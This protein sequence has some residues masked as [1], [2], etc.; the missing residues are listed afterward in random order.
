MIFSDIK[1]GK[2]LRSLRPIL[3]KWIRLNGHYGKMM[4]WSDCAWWSNERASTGVLAGAVW[5]CGGIALEEFST[6]K[7]FKKR[8]GTGRCDLFIAVGSNKKKKFACEIKQVFPRMK[9]GRAGEI[10]Q[11]GAK[12]DLA[13]EDARNLF[14]QEGRRL[15][16]CFVTPRFPCSRI[17]SMNNCL[18][19][20]LDGIQKR[21]EF[22]AVA[23]CFPK[24]AR[25]MTWLENGRT[26]PG[27]IILIREV[28]R[29]R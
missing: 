9:N 21:L 1:V 25:E 6:R 8:I 13:C 5:K 11:A 28:F 24:E 18:K 22:D 19:D 4:A 27:V 23:W 17:S 26:Y 14:P 20:Y 15:G 7:T 16:I 29:S 10:A 12:L 2:K 3:E